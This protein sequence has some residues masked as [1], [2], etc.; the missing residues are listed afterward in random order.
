MKLK[1]VLSAL[2]VTAVAAS[3]MAVMG[4]SAA[5]A[6]GVN[7]M[8]I[9]DEA[10]PPDDLVKDITYN[11]QSDGSWVLTQQKAED[12]WPCLKM[13][14]QGW[15]VDVAKTPYL[16]Y[17]VEATNTW[18]INVPI[19]NGTP[20]SM[21]AILS[22]N[23]TT[24]PDA[25]GNQKGRIDLRQYVESDGK[26]KE[27]GEISYFVV[28]PKNATVTIKQLYIAGDL[29]NGEWPKLTT[30]EKTYYNPYTATVETDLFNK[31]ASKWATVDISDTDNKYGEGSNPALSIEASGNGLKFA[32]SSK[33][34]AE[35]SRNWFPARL[36]TNMTGVSIS[37]KYLYYSFKAT[38]KW[39]LNLVFGSNPDDTENTL[40]LAPSI[41]Q[42]KNPNMKLLYSV[43]EGDGVKTFG[44]DQD[45]PAGAYVGRI[46]LEAAIK[47]AVENEKIK[48]GDPVKDG[49]I[50]LCAVIVWDI[51]NAGTTVEMDKLFLGNGGEQNTQPA[52]GGSAGGNSNGGNTNGG[53]S[54]G[55]NN[56]GNKTPSTGDVTYAYAAIVIMVAAAGAVVLFSR[57]AKN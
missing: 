41:M 50:D 19:G 40:K 14:S 33:L 38:G 39:N 6:T 23:P 56:G 48:A 3:S 47:K 20:I 53:N 27:I 43:A 49:K 30:E 5:D 28:G 10:V 22:A 4:V 12:F 2:M 16:Y 1:R 17:E 42:A 21:G 15:T 11:V 55:G 51:G 37:G 35:A 9:V 13:K 29:V 52:Y 44:Y 26:A 31:N 32:V 54:N 34:E 7:L 25:T 8:P 36:E 45:G 57:K 24:D 18:N 46:D